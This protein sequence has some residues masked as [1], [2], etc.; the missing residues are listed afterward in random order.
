MRTRWRAA[1]AGWV[2]TAGVAAGQTTPRPTPDIPPFTL[3]AAADLG[4]PH[5]TPVSRPLQPVAPAD[6]SPP[7]PAT[8]PPIDA[9]TLLESTAGPDARP[10]GNSWFATEYLVW[11]PKGQPLP[12]LVTAS[13]AGT[14]LLGG[15]NT[16]LLVGGSPADSPD[17]SGARFTFGWALNDAESAGI[18]LTYFFLGSR[19]T[20]ESV[21]E[22]G[23]TRPRFVGRPVLNPTTGREDVVAVAVPGALAGSIDVSATTR[24]TGWE[25][26]GVG[27]LYAG[28]SVRVNALAGYRYFVLNEGLRIDQHGYRPAAATGGAPVLFSSADQFDADNR[29]H[30]GQLGLHADITRGPIFAELT[31]KIGLGQSV[32]IVKISGQTVAVTPGSPFPLIYPDAAGVLGQ[33]SNAGR[34]ARSVFAVL[35][36]AA[37]KLG[38][39]FRDH[40]RLYVG[41]NFL[42][43]SDAVRPGDQ[44]D[45]GLDPAAVPLGPRTG[46]AWPGERPAGVLVRSD[47][48]VQGL[49][50]G[51][52]CRY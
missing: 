15:P 48:W 23:A 7:P 47:F 36:E 13:R 9:S 34:T 26:T 50:L 33:P 4:L 17:M 14:P 1:I 6:A 2:A 52:E 35:P 32:E 22:N 10:L 24:M 21:A 51:F 18:E 12:P 38:C 5:G 37:V 45:R 40:S 31:G 41:Y 19:T 39:R 49:I 46:P 27:S 8:S 30:G 25:I 42:Y 43:L 44:I 29:F 11:W 20:T 3:P 28:Q 16:V